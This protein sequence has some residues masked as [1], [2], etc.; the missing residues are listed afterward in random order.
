MSAIRWHLITG[1]YPPQSGGV[2]D[3]TALLARGL[4]S[5]G[6]TV[7]VWAPYAEGITPDA[8]GV[9]VRRAVEKWSPTDLNRLNKELNGYEKSRRLLV[10][11]T[12]NAWGYKGLNF[13]FCRWLVQRRNCGDDIR[14][15]IHEPFYPWRLWDKP[16][17]WL[18]AAGQRWMIR[19]LLGASSQ[20][21]L[22]IPG[23]ERMLRPYDPG[24]RRPMKWL[25]IPSTI[26]IV[27][28]PA[29]VAEFRRRLA[30]KGQ[31]ILGSFGTFGGAIREVLSKVLPPL[32]AKHP[33]RMGLLLGQGGDRFAAKLLAAHPMLDGRL[34]APG[35]LAP[36]AV[37]FHLQA[38][39]VLIQPYPDG[40]SSRRTSVM[41]GLSHGLP[42]VTTQGFLS[43]P[44]WEQTG[45]VALA[46]AS[47]SVQFIQAAESFL[48]DREASIRL[49]LRARAV[50]AEHFTLERTVEVLLKT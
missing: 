30:P 10:Q 17:R 31:A 12:P 43:E 9:T 11:Y 8:N 6:A 3:Y 4:A 13:G 33:E 44:I 42:T 15:M 35:R 29:R 50:Y 25:P 39:D 34:I 19:S 7:E 23:W 48:A 5:A 16:T 28:D 40:V 14:L 38:C 2:S 32:L 18:L 20:V 1:E 37:S 49:G 26:P 36:E 21:Y 41:A 47:D 22:S 27:V 46:P 24:G 45:C